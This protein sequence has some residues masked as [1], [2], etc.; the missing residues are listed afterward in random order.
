MESQKILLFNL[1]DSL[2]EDNRAILGQLIVARFQQAALLR[3]EEDLTQ[4]P[5]YLYLDEFQT[6]AN[7][8]V[9]SYEVLLS[10]AR[11]R[12]VPLILTHQFGDQLDDSVLHA[13][14]G[15]V[16][17][18]AVFSVQYTDARRLGHELGVPPASLQNQ[19]RS[20]CHCRTDSGLH[21]L[22]TAAPPSGARAE[23]A[24]QVMD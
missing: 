14:L 12:R 19:A 7:A 2:G 22:T 1:T 11:K 4:P 16:S 8:G 3:R 10:R 15:T 6:F 9:A 23:V 13:I 24:D 17:T 21:E 5:F 20:H 18:T